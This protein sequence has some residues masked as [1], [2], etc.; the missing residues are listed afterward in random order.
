MNGFALFTVGTGLALLMTACASAPQGSPPAATTSPA[1]WAQ[2]IGKAQVLPET[3]VYPSAMPGASG[4]VL[5]R[6]Y[7]GAPPMIPHDITAMTTS[8]E[9]N[10]CL[11]CH[12]NGEVDR[13]GHR[14]TPVP[15]SHF[16]DLYDQSYEQD[17]AKAIQTYRNSRLPSKHGLLGTR[18]AC[19]QCHAPQ[20]DVTPWVPST[21]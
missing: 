21:F 1:P 6:G 20:S 11:A 4:G 15:N 3:T 8:R 2:E 5:E 19:T 14:A 10:T 7:E 9:Y 13:A 18:Y 12:L 16:T 17:R